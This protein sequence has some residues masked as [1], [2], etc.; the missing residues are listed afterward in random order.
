MR[1][2]WSGV[3][4][5]ISNGLIVYD[6]VVQASARISQET[7]GLNVNDVRCMVEDKEGQIWL[8]TSEGI[9]VIYSPGNATGSTPAKAQ[10][11]ITID[12]ITQYLL[13][14]EII[15]AIAVDGARNGLAPMAVVF[16]YLLMEQKQIQNFNTSNSPLLNA[17]TSIAIDPVTGEVFIGTDKGLIFMLEM[18]HKEQSRSGLKVFPNR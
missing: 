2:L 15:T 9:A 1:L 6:P 12:G 4:T 17:I 8:G 18:P 16:Y 13:D 10:K 5:L 11:L 7:G 3:T 14:K